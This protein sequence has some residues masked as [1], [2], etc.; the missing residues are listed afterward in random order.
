[1]ATRLLHDRLI[2]QIALIALL[3]FPAPLFAKTVTLTAVDNNTSIC[4]IE[5]DSLVITLPSPIP[6]A[7]RWQQHLAKPSPLTAMNDDF[8]PAKDPKGVATQTFRFN[9][10]SVG[11]RRCHTEL[12]ETEA[13]PAPQITQTFSVQVAV[14]SGAPKSSVLIG[15]YK[16]TTACADCTGILTVLRLYAKGPNDFTDNIYISTRTYQGGRG[17]DQSFTDRGEWSV[18]KGD[19]V[20]PNATVYALSPDDPR[21]H[22]IFL[23]AAGRRDAHQLDNQ[24]K[25]IDAPAAISVDLETNGVKQLILD[26]PAPERN[27]TWDRRSRRT[28][29]VNECSTQ[30]LS[31]TLGGSIQFFPSLSIHRRQELL[32]HPHPRL[33]Q[34]LGRLQSQ[35]RQADVSSALRRLG[36]ADENVG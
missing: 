33:G 29:C 20:D 28:C 6:D 30:I 31:R 2:R 17:G 10:A 4:L 9:A 27:L 11:R 8:T 25:P 18:M 23:A 14:A 3:L 36:T 13:G 16:G 1:M 21:L 35:Q 15:T 5:G 7:Y 19:A 12:R 22:A 34:H 32:Q 24:M 26:A